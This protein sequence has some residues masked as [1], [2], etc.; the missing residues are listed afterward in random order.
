MKSFAFNERRWFIGRRQK[1]IPKHTHTRAHTNTQVHDPPNLPEAYSATHCE[2]SR[3]YAVQMP[4]QHTGGLQQLGVCTPV[5]QLRAVCI[6]HV[7]W[8]N[9]GKI[10]AIVLAVGAWTAAGRHGARPVAQMCRVANVVE[11]KLRSASDRVAT[12]KGN[13]IGGKVGDAGSA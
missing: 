10:N 9:S 1:E 7:E 11:Q 5:Y 13:M 4:S 6:S 2:P 12:K 3:A 8:R